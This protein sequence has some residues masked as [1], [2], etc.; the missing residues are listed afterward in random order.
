MQ[1]AAHAREKAA[2]PSRRTAAQVA[3]R[4]SAKTTVV[5][6]AQ[7]SG[8]LRGRSSLGVQQT[9]GQQP[10]A[11]ERL[12]KDSRSLL[13]SWGRLEKSR[14]LLEELETHSRNVEHVLNAC[15]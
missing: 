10:W 4:P 14:S 1:L 12:G 2:H 6:A 13:E 7:K 9:K 15:T 3:Q 11:L 5:Q 8:R